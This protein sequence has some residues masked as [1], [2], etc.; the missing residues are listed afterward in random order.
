MTISQ[1]I[2]VKWPRFWL[3]FFHPVRSDTY[4]TCAS[5]LIG[6]P[7]RAQQLDHDGVL[8]PSLVRACRDNGKVR[9]THPRRP[10]PAEEPPLRRES[11]PNSGGFLPAQSRADAG[12]AEDPDIPRRLRLGAGRSPSA[13]CSTNSGCRPAP[14]LTALG[15]GQR[16]PFAGPGRRVPVVANRLHPPRPARHRLAGWLRTGFLSDRRGR[17]FDPGI[18]QA[19]AEAGPG[20]PLPGR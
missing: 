14:R 3:D 18:E 6:R 9:T 19:G 15:R 11:Y 4:M 8:L 1:F 2:S 16:S 7:V 13:P 5:G 12:E 20:C 17:R 10:R